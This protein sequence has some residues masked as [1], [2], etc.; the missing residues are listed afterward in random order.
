MT[1]PGP[2]ALHGC[3]AVWA[4]TIVAQKEA[5]DA[6]T[7]KHFLVM[8]FMIVILWSWWFSRLQNNAPR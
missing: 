7:I 2:V 4:K 3:V 1:F 6:P 5:A 8:I